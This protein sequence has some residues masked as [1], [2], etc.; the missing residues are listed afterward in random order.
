MQMPKCETEIGKSLVVVI[1]GKEVELSC[2][3]NC[4]SCENSP[5]NCTVCKGSNRKDNPPEC[6]C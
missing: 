1:D 3:K 4:E 6:S 2:N 5:E